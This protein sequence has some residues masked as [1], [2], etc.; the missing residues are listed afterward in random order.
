MRSLSMWVGVMAALLIVVYLAFAST[1]PRETASLLGITLFAP[2]SD[3]HPE[4]YAYAPFVIAV[5]LFLVA[6]V[7]AHVVAIP[8]SPRTAGAW[9]SHA[10]LL[11]LAVG[12]GWYAVA[13]QSGDSYT[14][15][16]PQGW[17]PVRNV[18]LGRT[19]ALHVDDAGG[20]A[21]VQ[22]V[23]QLIEGLVPHGDPVK[24]DVPVAR[25][26]EGVSIRAVEFLPKARVVSHWEDISP[27]IIP[28]IELEVG[29]AGGAGTI[30]LSPSLPDRRFVSGR[31]YVLTYN[32]G[33]TPEGLAKYTTP[34][35]PNQGPGMPY[36]LAI[37]C[38]GSRIEPTLA[39][40]R[41]DGT[42]FSA[43]LEV[44][45]AIEA[46]LGG[47]TVRI[48]PRRFYRHAVEVYGLAPADE[49]V[50][51]GGPADPHEAPPGPVL[52]V[53]VT[54]GDFSRETVLPF[55]PY[56]ML[57][58]P[59]IVDLP[60]N[61]GVLLTFSRLRSALPATVRVS[62]PVYHTYP[63]SGIPKDYVCDFRIESGGQRRVETLSLNN[64]VMV[65]DFQFSQGSWYP[66]GS[67]A[68]TEIVFGA[69]TRPG[70]PLV[71]LGCWMICLGL[72]Y[73]FYVKPLLMRRRAAP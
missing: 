32:S 12:G 42:R 17:T 57:A 36:D 35:D 69:A 63:G 23:Q 59:Q 11:V 62:D 41:P 18:Y 22:S 28:A 65:G 14:R 73:A 55:A 8:L 29:D 27:N 19:F 49:S 38:T 53:L 26:P 60:G 9:I 47:Q 67:D 40:I 31:G 56:G 44:G 51:S 24:L 45:K 50:H 3:T 52:R 7:V 30:L 21:N 70:L 37:F 58:R 34:D 25:A 61:R 15:L 20:D 68:P 33:V 54:A 72:P 6:M 48:T 43:K 16:T 5:G 10:G 1:M 2:E 13:R 66:P 46:P 4:L 71:W 64:T 39:V